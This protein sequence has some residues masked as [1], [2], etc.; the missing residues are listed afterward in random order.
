MQPG[1]SIAPFNKDEL[2]RLMVGTK[3]LCPQ[4]SGRGYRWVTVQRISYVTRRGGNAAVFVTDP[5]W[6]RPT[7]VPIEILRWEGHTDEPMLIQMIKAQWEASKDAVPR[8]TLTDTCKR[9]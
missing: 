7:L 5:F 2:E 9:P 1:W 6:K 8:G 3:V 4:K